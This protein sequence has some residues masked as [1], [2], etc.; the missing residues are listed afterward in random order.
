MTRGFWSGHAS[1]VDE[2]AASGRKPGALVLAVGG[3]GL[4]CGVL[5][6]LHRI[7]WADVPVVAVETEGTDSFARSVAAGRLITLDTIRS[8][9]TSL[10]ARTV[11]SEA[12]AWTHR[13]RVIPQTVTD[14]AAIDGCLRFADEHRLLVE[15]ACGAALSTV[16]ARAEPLRGRK[17]VLIILCGGAGV[18]LAL[19]REWDRT[20]PR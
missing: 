7:G 14:R 15:P 11:A 2:V 12:L 9:A 1:L 4:L 6:G 13:H 3:G 5:E 20:V 16:Y 19:L 18:N 8:I 17:S 10:G